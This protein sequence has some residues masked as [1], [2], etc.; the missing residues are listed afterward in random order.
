VNTRHLSR[1][2]ILCLA[3]ST[4]CKKSEPASI[5]PPAETIARIHWSGKTTFAHNTNA[6]VLMNIL[7]LPESAKLETQTLEKLSRAPWP[8]LHLPSDPARSAL[9]R[10][11]LDDVLQQECCLEIRQATNEP[12]QLVF[13]I[14]LDDARAALWQTN[15]AAVMESLTGIRPNPA[16]GPR[17]GWSLQKH[18][19]PGL[20]ELIRLK[21]W[22]LLGAAQNHNALLDE[23]STR[24]EQQGSPFAPL[25]TNL[26]LEAEVD[27]ARVARALSFDRPLSPGF[28]KISLT[29][30]CEG[31]NVHTQLRLSFSHPLPFDPEPWLI[32]TNLIHSPVTSFTAVRGFKSV[33]SS[34]EIW[35]NLQ[36]GPPPNQY[37]AWSKPDL[38]MTT[39]FAAPWTDASN[40]I[41]ELTDYVLQKSGSSWP[42]NK[43]FGFGRA[44]KFNGLEWK[45]LPY[46]WPYLR[47]DAMGD[48]EFAFGGLFPTDESTG[49]PP[50]A[51]PH[52]V[53]TQT[54]L[55]AY[56]WESTGS[57]IG[58]WLYIG[59]F[60]RHVTLHAQLPPESASLKWLQAV[61][62]RFGMASTRVY[63]EA[64]DQLLIDRKSTVG[65]T[66]VEL[67]LIADWLESPEFPHGLNS[68]LGPQ[69]DPNEL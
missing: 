67:Q 31:T 38:I 53:L 15:L 6:V 44:S 10:P 43:Y 33:L 46:L 37:F 60:F 61:P 57:R 22:T 12:A 26:W 50:P 7:N 59:Q 45:G 66:A 28:P 41:R 9:L 35:T 49:W 23:L 8:L 1:C 30:S 36:I 2:L 58:S 69:E 21:T 55:V 52:D 62:S 14:R 11:L 39:F 24:I 48:H 16:T 64:P 56:G 19:E 4:G 3:I 63:L 42:T 5:A 65:F 34:L 54:N 13:A 68:I 40:H 25:A 32:P 18:Q 51:V 17:T 29:Q 47:S 27:P 20:I